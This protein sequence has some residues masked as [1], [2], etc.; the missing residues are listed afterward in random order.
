VGTYQVPHGIFTFTREGE[1]L[2]FE[3]AAT[4]VIRWF[5]VINTDPGSPRPIALAIGRFDPVTFSAESGGTGGAVGA[6]SCRRLQ[7]TPRMR[8]R[9]IA[10]IA[11]CLAAC[12]QPEAP[13]QLLMLPSG[14]RL[15]VLS[16]ET[17]TNGSTNTFQFDYLTSVHMFLPPT[18]AERQELIAEADEIWPVIRPDVEKAGL[19]IATIVAQPS[20]GSIAGVPVAVIG[21]AVTFKRGTDGTWSRTP[22]S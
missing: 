10:V 14:K 22:T 1:R 2:L 3:S 7:E 20:R 18:V 8:L 9:L 5:R 11:L 19:S 4:T 15:E 17:A 21:F 13:K 16:K 12:G 6:D